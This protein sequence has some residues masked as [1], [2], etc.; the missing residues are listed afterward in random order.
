MTAPGWVDDFRDL[1]DAPSPAVLATY[2]SDGSVSVSPVWYRVHEGA[3]EVVI[4]EGDPKLGH[5]DADPRCFLMIFET[6]VPFRG[7]KFQ[8]PPS[9]DP[10]VEDQARTAVST[11]FLGE[12]RASRFVASRRS[13]G[14]VLRFDLDDGKPWDQSETFPPG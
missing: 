7:V 12:E 6:T 11:R 5:L 2:R 10:D 3:V 8:T 13:P 14:V 9:V 4:A 1:L